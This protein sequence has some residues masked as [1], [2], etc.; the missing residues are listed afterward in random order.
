M[1]NIF[2]TPLNKLLIGGAGKDTKPR[3]S[4]KL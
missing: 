2:G 3:P 1:A 4:W